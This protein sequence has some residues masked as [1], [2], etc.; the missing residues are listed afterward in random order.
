M[1][2]L[3]PRWSCNEYFVTHAMSGEFGTA[4]GT[5]QIYAEIMVQT[6]LVTVIAQMYIFINAVRS[7]KEVS[8]CVDVL[9]KD[10][11]E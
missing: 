3:I 5:R 6:N 8:I 2:V 9:L 1:L 7:L 11:F 10:F 4:H